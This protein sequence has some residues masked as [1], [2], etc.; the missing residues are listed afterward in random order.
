MIGVRN[1]TLVDCVVGYR[2]RSQSGSTYSIY[3]DSVVRTEFSRSW[4]LT[5]N[6]YISMSRIVS[7]FILRMVPSYGDC[8][9]NGR[10]HMCLI[11]LYY[12]QNILSAIGQKALSNSRGVCQKCS[13]AD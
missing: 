10:H 13:S 8:A 9:R 3:V 5:K 2:T 6:E 12:P 1:A 7:S 4:K 11:A